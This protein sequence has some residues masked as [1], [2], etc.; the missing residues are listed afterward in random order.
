MP[1]ENKQTPKAENTT[2]ERIIPFT[3]RQCKETNYI[4]AGTTEFQCTACQKI[5]HTCDLE[6]CYWPR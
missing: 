6:F 4:K 2:T 5:I 1:E 3:C